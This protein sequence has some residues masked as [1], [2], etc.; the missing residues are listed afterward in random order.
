V[1]TVVAQRFFHRH[2]VGAPLTQPLTA[3]VRWRHLGCALVVA[4]LSAGRAGAQCRQPASRF[5]PQWASMPMLAGAVED[6]QRMLQDL[7]RCTP[8]GYLVRSTSAL[9]DSLLGAGPVR[10]AVVAPNIQSTWNTALPFSMNDGTEWAGRGLTT[11]FTTGVRVEA[12]RFSATFA[13]QFVY[14]QNRDFLVFASGAA[15]RSDFAS[16]WHS[17]GESADLPLRFGDQPTRL[18]TLG[19]SR[20]ELNVGPMAVGGSTEALWWG[21]GIRNALVMSNNAGGIPQLFVRTARPIRTPIGDLEGRWLV[22]ALT[23]SIYFDSDPSNDVRSLSSVVATLNVAFDRGLTVG[24]ARSVYASV[25][26]GSAVFGHAFDAFGR[27]DQSSDSTRTPGTPT[28]QI[29]SLFGRWVFPASGVE[30]YGEWAKLFP[31]SGLREL[32]V[33]PQR[34]QGFT[35]GVQWVRPVRAASLLRTQF[36][37]TMLE[38]T[39]PALAAPV[40]SFYTSRLVPQ[41]Y[42]QRGQSIGAAIGPGSSSQWL[43]GDYIFGSNRAGLFVGRIRWE[44]EAYYRQPSSVAFF[45][46]DVSIFAGIRGGASFYGVDLD[47]ALQHTIRMNYLFQTATSGYAPSPAFDIRSNAIRMTITPINLRWR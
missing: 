25:S 38:Q 45:A 46:H 23:E 30:I 34:G 43:A 7:G 5:D 21:P 22:G 9:T 37:A 1:S 18:A 11:T 44:D 42:T 8:A 28:D 47:L 32:V 31:P 27:W 40:R 29:Y 4:I 19:E 33:E 6:R 39:P 14:Q 10:W 17:I 26:S 13:P 2:G 35:V 24:A 12:G 36:E 20:A 16:P 41:G 15:G 3:P